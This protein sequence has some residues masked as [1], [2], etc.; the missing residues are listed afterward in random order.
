MNKIIVF[1]VG[2]LITRYTDDALQRA[3]ERDAQTEEAPL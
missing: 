3:F 1:A 2:W